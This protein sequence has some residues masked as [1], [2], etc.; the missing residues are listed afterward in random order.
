MYRAVVCQRAVL[1]GQ[2]QPQHALFEG[3]NDCRG[4]APHFPQAAAMLHSEK[5][6]DRTHV[7]RKSCPHPVAGGGRDAAPRR[8]ARR[9]RAHVAVPSTD[10][11]VLDLGVVPTARR[12]HTTGTGRGPT[13][14]ARASSL[15][16]GTFAHE[17]DPWAWC[18]RPIEGLCECLD[19]QARFLQ[20]GWALALFI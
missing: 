5:P 16:R 12:S 8:S 7:P 15:G 3:G 10:L 2:Q 4:Q 14:P 9:S 6:H 17:V 13:R 20:F 18:P 11:L 1:G 19:K